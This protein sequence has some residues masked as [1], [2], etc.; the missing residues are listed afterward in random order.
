T[1][2]LALMLGDGRK[3]FANQM[4]AEAD[5]Y[6]HRGNYP[7]IFDVNA[8]KEE[9]HMKGGA[10]EEHE[11]DEHHDEHEEEEGPPPPRDW[12]EAFGRH[13]Y[14]SVHV[15]LKEGEQR[16]MLPWFR[17]SAE[18]D[19]HRIDTYTV[20]SYWLERLGKVD[21]ATDFLRDGLRA[22]P[23]DPEILTELGRLFF[24]G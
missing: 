24:K 9:H 8:R 7:S 5:A 6:F 11:H 17:F 18:L 20:A 12:I 21:E 23:G 13:F 15:H 22:N 16:E 4:F 14:P 10:E 1:D 19:P 2:V 3:M